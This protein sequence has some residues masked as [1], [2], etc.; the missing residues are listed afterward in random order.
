MVLLDEE[1]DGPQ[2]F[3]PLRASN[4]ATKWEKV[5][6]AKHDSQKEKLEIVVQVLEL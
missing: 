5:T 3:S 6:S 1:D 4:N 2:H